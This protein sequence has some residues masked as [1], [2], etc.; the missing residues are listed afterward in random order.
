MPGAGGLQPLGLANAQPT[1]FVPV[2]RVGVEPTDDH[3]GLN[4]A[5]LPVCVP[6]RRCLKRPRW[7]L[8]PRSPA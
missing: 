1:H 3:Q 4:L 6:C 5:A 7:D 8:N 2:A